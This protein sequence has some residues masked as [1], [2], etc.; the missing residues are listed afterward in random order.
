[1]CMQLGYSWLSV[2]PHVFLTSFPLSLST[3][4]LNL[5]LLSRII[6]YF[7]HSNVTEKFSRFQE[8]KGI[9]VGRVAR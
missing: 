2:P 9:M 5:S 6:V 3:I 8:V 1:M 7:F 4:P